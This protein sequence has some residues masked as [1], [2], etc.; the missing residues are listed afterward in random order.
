MKVRLF[1]TILA[2]LLGGC[3]MSHEE[4][5]ERVKYCEDRGLSAKGFLS[6]GGGVY[7][8]DCINSEGVVFR[9]KKR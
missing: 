9:S 6:T 2:T 5:A 1:V 4:Y 8:V 7:A 3:E